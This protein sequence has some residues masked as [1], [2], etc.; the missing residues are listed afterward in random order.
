MQVPEHSYAII[1][2]GGGGTRLWP[3][4]R[5]KTPKHLLNL[6]GEQSMLQMTYNRI[7]KLLPEK[8]I[9][10]VTLKVYEKDIR[11]Q[12]PSLTKDHIIIE[13][14]SNNTAL[15][16]GIGAA[17]IYKIDPEAVVINI[18]ADHLIEKEEK[19]ANA[20][21]GSL[22]VASDGSYLVAIGIRPS[23]PHIGLGYIHIGAQLEN[24]EGKKLYVFKC[25]GFKEKPD[26]T[27]AQ[28]FIASKEYLWN[29]GLY[30]WAVRSLFEAFDQHSPK[31]GQSLRKILDVLGTPDEEDVV[32]RI[33]DKSENIAIDYAIS[34]KAKNL[35]VV[36]GDFT[37]SDIG[38]WQG[39]YENS[40]K[41]VFGNVVSYVGNY[42]GIDT[43]NSLIEANG[44]MVVTIGLEDIVVVDTKDALLI[45]SKNRSQ[46]VKKAIEKLKEL[47]RDDLL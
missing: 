35:V 20:V 45:C 46:D 7:A 43:K 25:K 23:F 31:I 22:Q 3:K 17:Y 41:D 16:M 27:T 21:I 10:I 42:L 44:R 6:F 1:L 30:T 40:N 5:K 38:D 29:A 4:S 9:Y 12:I 2:A 11:E 28:S 32:T 19:F 39:L 36:P 26:L 33:Y 18:A 13:P 47:K 24:E 34:E 15:A 37:W 14:K 8:N